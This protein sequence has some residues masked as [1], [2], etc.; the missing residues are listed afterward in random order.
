M[1]LQAL[2]FTAP[3]IEV[4]GG[5]SFKANEEGLFLANLWLRTATRI[6]VRI[7][8]FCANTFHDLDS[9]ISK[10]PWHLYLSEES[11]IKFKVDSKGSKLYHE[12]GIE[13]RFKEYIIR[14]FK[15]V[16]FI[17]DALSSESAKL[18][19]DELQYGVQLFSIKAEKNIFTVSVDSSGELLHRRGYRLAS[20]KAPIRETI[21]AGILLLLGYDG[22]KPLIDPMCGSGTF[23]I[24][25]AMISRNIAPGIHRKFQ[26]EIWPEFPKATVESLRNKSR[27]KIINAMKADIISSDR[28]NGVIQLAQQNAKRANVEKDI[29]FINQAL[30][31]LKPPIYHNIEEPAH[32]SSHLGHVILNPPYGV[33]VSSKNDLRNLYAQ[34]GNVMRR[35]CAGWQFCYLSSCQKLDRQIKINTEVVTRF[36][37]G[38]I[39]IAVRNGLVKTLKKL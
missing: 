30:S 5:V 23:A 37:N 34:I 12:K 39:P 20:G 7:H 16:N 17:T 28:D 1:E 26:C 8:N 29:I 19:I 36:K 14:N 4:G 27:E 38:G 15:K 35:H 24:E 10:I 3:K 21:A 25:A 22:S 18:E 13:E 31:A 2:G 6:L 9:E 33:R 32:V 11:L